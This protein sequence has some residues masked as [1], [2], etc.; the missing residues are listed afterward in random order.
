MSDS[1]FAMVQA[2][3]RSL[4]T[5]FDAGRIDAAAFEAALDATAFE[6]AGR[7]W[8]IGADSGR[9][10]ASESGNW[11]LATPPDAAGA[12]G[13]A[14]PRADTAPTAIDFAAPSAGSRLRS[15]LGWALLAA[16]PLLAFGALLTHYAADEYWDNSDP[17]TA[18]LVLG[19][20]LASV[21]AVARYRW[22]PRL[23]A[24]IVALLWTASGFAAIS[25]ELGHT[26]DIWWW[27]DVLFAT[28]CAAILGAVGGAWLRRHVA[29]S[30]P[31]A[32]DRS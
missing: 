1:R 27:P 32:A 31:T 29:R 19:V 10:Y 13:H 8:M 7:W 17:G 23:P 6:H 20:L 16:P 18:F 24:F 30:E 14:G 12:T 4:R 3:Y 25:F 15:L 9:W 2:Q 22:I 21:R 5:A 26:S 11:V 28:G